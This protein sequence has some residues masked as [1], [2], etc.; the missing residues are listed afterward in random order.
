MDMTHMSNRY[1][2]RHINYLVNMSM[3]MSISITIITYQLSS[4]S[5]LIYNYC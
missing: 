3:D 4:I 5:G 1:E 2:H